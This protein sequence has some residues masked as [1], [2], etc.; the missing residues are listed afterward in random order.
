MISIT[1]VN[2]SI[3][4]ALAK[5]K[6]GNLEEPD[7]TAILATSLPKII[8]DCSPNPDN[9]KAG[10]CFVHQSPL[11]RFDSAHK[12]KSCELGDLLVLVRKTTADDIRYNASFVQMKRSSDNP[13]LRIT[14]NGDLKQLFLYERWPCFTIKQ[15]GKQYNIFPKTV[16]QGA[17]Y[18]IIQENRSVSV[19]FY[20]SEPMSSLDYSSSHTFGRFIVNLVEW[21]TGR[22]ISDLFSKD[23]DEWSRLVW[24]VVLHCAHSKFNRRKSGFEDAP[25]AT[26]D[27]LKHLLEETAESEVAPGS[28]LEDPE[29]DETGGSGFHLLFIDVDERGQAN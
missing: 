28:S 6:A 11:A 18:C 26:D 14:Q 25:R 4:K 29:S 23:S 9:I 17:W 2:S 5:I 8:K 21:K 22:S 24:D 16:S 1:E 10:S 12:N 27:I 13:P 3:Q 20:M 19:Q 7:Y 15:F